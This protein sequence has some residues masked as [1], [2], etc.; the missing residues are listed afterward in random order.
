MEGKHALVV[1]GYP[2]LINKANRHSRQTEIEG[3]ISAIGTVI[4]QTDIVGKPR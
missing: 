3:K 4:W 1:L 2:M